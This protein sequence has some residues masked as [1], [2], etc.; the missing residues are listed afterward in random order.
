M[1]FL[2]FRKKSKAKKALDPLPPPPPPALVLDAD[3]NAAEEAPGSGYHSP[4]ADSFMMVAS[5]ISDIA[6]SSLSEDIFKELV[7]LSIKSETSTKSKDAIR[8]SLSL[9][10]SS[11]SV[12]ISPLKIN[13]ATHSSHHMGSDSIQ[14][15][16]NESIISNTT[17]SSKQS[18]S[19]DSSFTSLSSTEEF[20]PL[21]PISRSDPHNYVSKKAPLMD[22][23]NRS[24]LHE[25]AVSPTTTAIPGLAMARMKERHR[26]EYRRSMQWPPPAAVMMEY[27]VS[28]RVNSFTG[29]RTHPMHQLPP[30]S[31]STPLVNPRAHIP[32]IHQI[33]PVMPMRSTS[34]STYTSN[35]LERRPLIA[36]IPQVNCQ[37]PKPVVPVPDHRSY[38]LISNSGVPQPYQQ[39]EKLTTSQARCTRQ[40]LAGITEHQYQ[41]Q[42]S[43]LHG[44]EPTSTSSKL[45]TDYRRIV[46]TRKKGYVP[47]L[48]D[49]L[50]REDDHQQQLHHVNE[51]SSTHCSHHQPHHTLTKRQYTTTD[52]SHCFQAHHS[53]NRCNHQHHHHHHHHHHHQQQRHFAINHMFI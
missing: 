14:S 18:D 28:K 15:P 42:Q 9:K 29:H 30:P 40:R 8:H 44:V 41:Q 7:P 17:R 11:N 12:S 10:S 31:S 39:A 24:S 34:S 1:G 22:L 47:D 46:Y 20:V 49:L 50:D 38:H 23:V 19:S 25:Q 35:P 3:I 26:Q 48:V 37:Q 53:M 6:Q 5:S 13:T 51:K 52:N 32:L 43:F 45:K 36:I 21:H 27:P 4:I 2:S 33:K 16:L